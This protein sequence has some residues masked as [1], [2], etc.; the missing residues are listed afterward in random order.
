MI[1]PRWYQEEALDA[2]YNFFMTHK[3][4]NPL[5]GLPTGTG[6]SI[7]PAIF[8]E[9]IMKQWPNQRFLLTTHVKELIVQNANKMLEVW[10]EAPL[11]VYSAGLKIKHTAN[12][13]VF[14]GIQSMIKNAPMFG[15]RDIAFV[16]EAHLI[17]GDESSQ[18]QTF[19]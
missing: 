14:G 10:P 17:S 7:L 9:R 6:K 8:I 3:E 1:T 18:Y 15:H 5:I 4:G 19:F 16:D 2:I 13:I 12:P 11:G